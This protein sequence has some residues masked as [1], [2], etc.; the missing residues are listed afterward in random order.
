MITF[1]KS[2]VPAL[3]MSEVYCAPLSEI[4]SNDTLFNLFLEQIERHPKFNGIVE[5]DAGSFTPYAGFD[6]DG[7]LIEGTDTVEGPF[8]YTSTQ[9]V[10]TLRAQ[11][12]V[13]TSKTHGE[14]FGLREMKSL[15][16]QIAERD[17]RK[18]SVA[19][20]ASKARV[21]ISPDDADF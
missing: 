6:A 14:Y 12:I 19:K 4:S 20:P 5:D 9:F 7:Y 16:E 21:S 10:L 8:V 3:G 17:I 18:K 13:K 15:K 11:A 1:I 2:S